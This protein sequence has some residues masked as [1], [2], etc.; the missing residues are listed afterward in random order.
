MAKKKV[1]KRIALKKEVTLEQ[2]ALL[3]LETA[4]RLKEVAYFEPIITANSESITV[5][6]SNIIKLNERIDRIVNAI[7]KSKTVRGL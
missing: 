5:L 1:K 2:V 6:S 3:G 4:T 7:S